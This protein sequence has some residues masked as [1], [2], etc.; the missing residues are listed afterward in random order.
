MRFLFSGPACLLKFKSHQTLHCLR[1]PD[2]PSCPRNET[3]SALLHGLVCSDCGFSSRTLWTSGLDVLLLVWAC[4]S[5]PCDHELPA[6]PSP[7]GAAASPCRLSRCTWRHPPASPPWSLCSKPTGHL[8][9]C[10]QGH[11]CCSSAWQTLPQ[12]HTARSPLKS[13][14]PEE[15]PPAVLPSTPRS[16][17]HCPLSIPE[18]SP[19]L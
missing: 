12:V 3:R 11:T 19:R 5:P 2:G 6:A 15:G 8:H 10:A 13:S 16:P 7:Q 4:S 14:P 1:P 17:F 9:S 18:R